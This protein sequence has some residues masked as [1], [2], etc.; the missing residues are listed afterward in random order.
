MEK[1][2]EK[3][4]GDRVHQKEKEE[5]KEVVMTEREKEVVMTEKEV[6][7]TEI[8]VEM[9]GIEVEIVEGEAE[10]EAEVG[11][12]RGIEVVKEVEM[13]EM[14]HLLIEFDIQVFMSSCLDTIELLLS[15]LLLV[16]SLL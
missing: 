2:V 1:E 12:L 7:M 5:E 14:I 10:V 4:G 6:V 13:T 16:L 11:T 8:E 9:A 15:L 3:G